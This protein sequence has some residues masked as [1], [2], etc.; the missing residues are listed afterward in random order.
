[1]NSTNESKN[2]KENKNKI[3]KFNIKWLIQIFLLVSYLGI[4]IAETPDY[5]FKFSCLAFFIWLL[6]VYLTVSSSKTFKYL[7][8]VRLDK[9]FY[10]YMSALFFTPGKRTL[11]AECY[12]ETW[13]SRGQIKREKVVTYT[14][15]KVFNYVSWRDISGI[16]DID[17]KYLDLEHPNGLIRLH[18]TPK[19]DL[20]IDGSG[21]DYLEIKNDL[22]NKIK[23]KDEHYAIYEDDVIE[24]L[25]ERAFVRI[26]DK[27]P[28]FIGKIWIIV[29]LVLQVVEF[30]KLYFKIKATK[31]DFI[32]R[33]VVSSKANPKYNLLNKENSDIYSFLQP[34]IVVGDKK[35]VWKDFKNILYLN[36]QENKDED[37][38]NNQ[39]P[40]ID[41]INV[42]LNIGNNSQRENENDKT[43]IRFKNDNSALEIQS[44][45]D[46]NKRLFSPIIPNYSFQ[47]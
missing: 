45:E 38:I 9:S 41:N 10:N 28:L 7:M 24:G 31:K 30:Y 39:S 11:K 40:R 6:Q 2:K 3:C 14:E 23:N 32:V 22:V 16:M 18:L 19:V 44:L 20:A 36:K 47:K 26:G 8:K 42:E 29:A 1:M 33:K 43:D 21:L 5:K 17:T 13:S 37:V 27:I 12:H 4:L 25:E 46:S 35:K 34:Q 15:E